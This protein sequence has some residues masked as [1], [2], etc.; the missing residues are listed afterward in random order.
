MAD[1]H[2]TDTRLPVT[3]LS[4]FLGAG[5]TTLLNHVLANREGL[6]VAV[7]VNDMSEVNIDASLVERGAENAGAALS[8][9]EEKMVEMS[10]GCICC[11]LR[12]DLLLEV[13]KLAAE[14]RF[15]YLLIESTGIGEPM[16]VA[17]TFD[18]EDEAGESL[19][20]VARIDTMVTVVDALNLLTDFRSTDLLEQRGE[21]AGPEDNRSLAA[22]LTEQIEFADVVVINKI[23]KVDAARRD[24]VTAV[25]KALNPVAEVVYA[26]HGQVPLKQ[27][28]GT[29]RFDLERA[30]SM[31][32]WARELEGAHT[33]ETEAYGIESFV[34]RSRE[35]LHPWR[36][37]TFMD[38]PLPGLIRAKGY[39]W[40]AS[41]AQWVVSYS[42]AGNTATHEPVGRW[43]ASAPRDHWPPKGS[44]QRGAIEARWQEPWGD[45][46][47]E[48][49]FIGRNLDRAAIEQ[50]WRA[51]HLNYTEGRKGLKGW[52]ELPDPFPAWDPHPATAA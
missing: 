50:A 37:S 33:P 12:E 5:K 40:L 16:P 9:T 2:P 11:T 3:V 13:R 25:V 39:V 27:I 43:W 45:R 32:G 34:L 14:G 46:L 47:N 28:L 8:R 51:M 49:V 29:G 42:R 44:P 4:G 20:Q 10:N 38:Q 31:P 22:L 23:D 19:N 24:E 26:D 21:T 35:P 41:R 6:R 52:A 30:S 7:I 36:F 18:F 17:A 48:V 1:H 15:D